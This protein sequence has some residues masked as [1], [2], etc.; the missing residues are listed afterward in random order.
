MKKKSGFT[1]IELLVVIAIIA[2]LAAILFP[3]FAQARQKAK[4]A[5]CL[6]NLKQ[7]GLGLMMYAQDYD[8]ININEWPIWPYTDY[9]HGWQ[10]VINGAYAHSKPVFVDPGASDGHLYITNNTPQFPNGGGMTWTF[11]MNETGWA[12]GGG[13]LGHGLPMG[14]IAAPAD[15]IIVLAATGLTEWGPAGGNYQV[16]YTTDAA[17]SFDPLPTQTITWKNLYNVPGADWSAEGF[18]LVVPIRYQTANPVM[19]F[20]GHAKV[21]Q[22]MTGAEIDGADTPGSPYKTM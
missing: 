5:S 2:I 15:Q 18:P 20:D 1:L 11:A 17:T 22:N 21:L 19:F 12:D 14:K 8:E 16:A 13:Y 9:D 4:E 6:S 7:I 3:V 10:Q